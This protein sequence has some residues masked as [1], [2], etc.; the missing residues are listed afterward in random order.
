MPEIEH[1]GGISRRSFVT[2]VVTFLGSLIASVIGIPAIGYMISP[3]LQKRTSDEWVPIG[4]L[5][6][7]PMDIPVLSTFTR[8]T[9]VGW[10]RS[11]NTFG[12]Y[13]IRKSDG[14]LDIFSNV[15]THLSCRVSWKDDQ[16]AFVCPCHNGIFS[17]DG[18]IV[19]G[20]QPRPL[21]RYE[22]KIE[23]GTLLVHL[24]EG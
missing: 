16:D 9:Q 13:V 5:D 19:S 1:G 14:E 7:I 21:D 12:V 3:G 6:D 11:A 8:T 23:D 10:E 2:G 20:P 4:K 18:S 17:K 15:C 24:V 22:Y